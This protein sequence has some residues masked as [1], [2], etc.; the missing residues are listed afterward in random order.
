[1]SRRLPSWLE[2]FSLLNPDK[3]VERKRK[4]EKLHKERM[5]AMN[6]CEYEKAEHL[7]KRIRTLELRR[8]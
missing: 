4:L 7:E 2:W 5:H 1:M 6:R 3:E 8:R